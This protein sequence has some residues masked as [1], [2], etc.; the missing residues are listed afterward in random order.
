MHQITRLHVYDAT[1]ALLVRCGI[2]I[3]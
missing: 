2:S 1:A 3:V